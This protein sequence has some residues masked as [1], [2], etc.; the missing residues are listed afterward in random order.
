MAL[1]QNAKAPTSVGVQGSAFLPES[2]DP[3]LDALVHRLEQLEAQQRVEA[4]QRNALMEQVGAMHALLT[5]AMK[6]K[7][8]AE[9]GLMA[10][11][12]ALMK[13]REQAPVSEEERRNVMERLQHESIDQMREKSKRFKQLLSTSPKVLVYN[14]GPPVLLQMN[15]VRV[16]VP[17][18]KSEVPELF[19]PVWEEHMEAI[20]NADVRSALIQGSVS[21]GALEAWRFAG[22][23]ESDIALVPGSKVRVKTARDWNEDAGVA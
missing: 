18:G 16:V 23:Q 5:Q 15:S 20:R 14:P 12:E 4:L 1:K 19:L 8:E 6:E 17:T 2:A 9:Q 11:Q 10:A 3:S 21:F 13:V 7:Q 22:Q